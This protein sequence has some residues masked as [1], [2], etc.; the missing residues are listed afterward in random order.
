[1]ID[2]AI[3]YLH[4]VAASYAFTQRWQRGGM[5]DGLLSVALL[6][7]VFVIGW[8][9]TSS[10]AN[11]ILPNAWRTEMFSSDTLALVLLAMLETVFF[12]M[13]FLSSDEQ[14]AVAKA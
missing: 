14:Q 8:S 5:K 11:V 13:Y 4:I 6:G 9:L 3:F 10:I 7:L 2:L 1:M 12:K